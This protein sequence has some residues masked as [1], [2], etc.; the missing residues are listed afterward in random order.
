MIGSAWLCFI[1]LL[2]V[3]WTAKSRK[4]ESTFHVRGCLAMSMAWLFQRSG[5]WF[6]HQ[7]FD[8]LAFARIWSAFMLTGFAIS[9]VLLIDRLA[10]AT[11]DRRKRQKLSREVTLEELIALDKYHE[12]LEEQEQKRA[13]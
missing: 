8:N 13:E 11:K 3:A 6:M 9:C 5:E 1:V 12:R 10:D 4:T 2:V 7:F